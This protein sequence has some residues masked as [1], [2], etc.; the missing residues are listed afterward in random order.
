MGDSIR[1]PETRRCLRCDRVERWD[2]ADGTWRVDGEVGKVYCVHTWDITG[3][4]NPV[5]S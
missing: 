5:S 4:F 3:S 1:Y 2:E